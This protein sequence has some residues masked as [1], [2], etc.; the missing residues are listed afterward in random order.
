MGAAKA[1]GALFVKTRA[2]TNF[3]NAKLS[4]AREDLVHEFVSA[5]IHCSLSRVTV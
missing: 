2:A 4:T 5:W 3:V 1:C